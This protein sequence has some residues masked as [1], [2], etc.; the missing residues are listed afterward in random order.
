M[1]VIEETEKIKD[2]LNKLYTRLT[3]GLKYITGKNGWE[4]LLDMDYN[5]FMYCDNASKLIN[6]KI[7]PNNFK[8]INGEWTIVCA[9]GK[10]HINHL[11]IMDYPI[12]IQNVNNPTEHYNHI[13]LGSSCIKTTFKYLEEI[14][15][16]DDFKYKVKNW[17]EKIKEEEKKLRCKKCISCKEYKVSKTTKY[18]NPSNYLWCKDCAS[19]GSVKCIECGRWRKYIKDWKGEPMK[20]CLSCW[21]SSKYPSSVSVQSI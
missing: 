5:R 6:K 13:I 11:S 1:S 21:K 9:C 8:K 4:A 10:E 12:S 3:K 14:E 18:K 19:G 16:I 15:G 2:I 17:V 20:I 7:C